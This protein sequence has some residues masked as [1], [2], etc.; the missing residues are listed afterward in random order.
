MI[1]NDI[2][3]AAERLRAGGVV[4]IPTETVYGLAAD[5]R[6]RAAVARVFELRPVDD[7]VPSPPAQPGQDSSLPGGGR[8]L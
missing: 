2:D 1:S 8:T 7:A 5:A 6:N 3:L 4:A